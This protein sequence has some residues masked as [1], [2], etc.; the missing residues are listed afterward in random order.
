[1]V[2]VAIER[3]ADGRGRT[4]EGRRRWGWRKLP[5]STYVN[6]QPVYHTCINRAG[7]IA[8]FCSPRKGSTPITERQPNP[9]VLR[10]LV[11]PCFRFLFLCFSSFH[12]FFLVFFFCCGLHILPSQTTELGGLDSGAGSVARIEIRL[13]ILLLRLLLLLLLFFI[14]IWF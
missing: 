9:F 11:P 6:R 14:L 4:K 3:R 10:L 2:V 5:T 8:C 12:S 13:L 7:L 1:M